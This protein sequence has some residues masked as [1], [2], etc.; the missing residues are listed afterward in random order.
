[1]LVSRYI[2]L[3][4]AATRYPTQND[5][6]EVRPVLFVG[7]GIIA[8]RVHKLLKLVVQYRPHELYHIAIDFRGLLVLLA[9][10]Q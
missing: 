6:N 10:R 1:M 7:N 8:V 2:V 5:Y 4:T 3:D 9:F